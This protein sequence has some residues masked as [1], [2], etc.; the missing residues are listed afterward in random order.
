MG[1]TGVQRLERHSQEYTLVYDFVVH[2][3]TVKGLK[4]PIQPQII[5]SGDSGEYKVYGWEFDDVLREKIMNI[6]FKAI[7]EYEKHCNRQMLLEGE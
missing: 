3:M 7:Y 2:Q 1:E 6:H 5:R 4:S